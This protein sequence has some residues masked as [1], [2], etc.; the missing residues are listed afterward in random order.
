MIFFHDSMCF[1]DVTKVLKDS[2]F[3]S[4]LLETYLFYLVLQHA[5]QVLLPCF[6]D[7]SR[8]LSAIHIQLTIFCFH[9]L[10]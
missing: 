2:S 7:H 9:L 10:F 8:F 3:K 4:T 6:S 5:N 1:V